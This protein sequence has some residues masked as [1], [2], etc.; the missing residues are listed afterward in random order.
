ML[1]AVMGRERYYELLQK[2][3]ASLA[4][5]SPL[6]PLSVD[7][8]DLLD[9]YIQPYIIA[10]VDLRI[11]TPLTT[12]IR[13]KSAGSGTDANHTAATSAEL[14]RLQDQFRLDVAAYR[15]ELVHQLDKLDKNCP[16]DENTTL[17]SP[18][19]IRFV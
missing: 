18:I 1:K 6:V 17:K 3:T 13:S 16:L 19:N 15:E 9:N 7:D 8:K 10:A 4:P 2:V 5:T 12:E 14:I 11:V